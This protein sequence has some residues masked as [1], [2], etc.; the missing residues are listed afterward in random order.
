VAEAGWEPLT[1]A[2]ASNPTVHVERFG[3]RYLTIFND[4]KQPQETTITTE[5]DLAGPTPDLVNGKT[6]DWQ[7]KKATLTLSPEDVAM[8]KL[9]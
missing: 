6:L 2:V 5:I 9:P 1:H 4:S 8:I 7:Q 3:D